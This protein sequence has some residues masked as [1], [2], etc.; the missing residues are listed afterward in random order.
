VPLRRLLTDD[1]GSVLVEATVMMGITLIFV[2]GSIDF[3]F[4]FYQ[5]NAAA[6][7]VEVGARIA[8]VSDP[9]AT[10]LNNLSSNVLS[11][12]VLPGS[13]MPSFTVRCPGNAT[14][15]TCTGT[16]TGLG[17]NPSLDQTALETIVYG[18][19]NRGICNNATSI[20]FAA[21]CNMFP[22]LTPANVVVVYRQTGLGYAGRPGGPVPTVEVSLQGVNFQYFFLNGL[23]GFG[24][25]QVPPSSTSP[26]TITGEV[27]SSSAQC[28]NGPC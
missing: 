12:S 19:G 28:L 3:L 25:K 23:L 17:A 6:K 27:L 8:A 14:N 26:T 22:G 18:R 15:C 4:A 20:Y 9:V 7:A 11:S 2:L 13:P 24:P 16:C 10:G 1:N 21:M 5:W